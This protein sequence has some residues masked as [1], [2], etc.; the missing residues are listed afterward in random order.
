MLEQVCA[1][2]TGLMLQTFPISDTPAA[3]LP[4]T[5]HCLSA[6]SMKNLLSN[7]VD[8]PSGYPPSVLVNL[9]FFLL[10]LHQVWFC[11]E[12]MSF[13][14]K[15]THFFATTCCHALS[16][17]SLCS[18]THQLAAADM[19]SVYAE[20]CFGCSWVVI[21]ALSALAGTGAVLG[22]VFLRGFVPNPYDAITI[23]NSGNGRYAGNNGYHGYAHSSLVCL[24]CVMP[25]LL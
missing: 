6:C 10:S 12:E 21:T 24:C 22:F 25:S 15:Q 5:C 9:F 1:R 11:T 23:S 4:A 14:G 3:L 17:R 20:V 19:F 7:D 8:I 13:L 2:P 18:T 16:H